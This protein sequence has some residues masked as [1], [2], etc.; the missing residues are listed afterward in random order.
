MRILISIPSLGACT[1]LWLAGTILSIWPVFLIFLGYGIIQIIQTVIIKRTH[2]YRRGDYFLSTVDLLGITLGIFFTGGINSPLFF[3]YFI[4]LIVKVFHRNWELILYNGIGGIVFYAVVILISIQGQWSQQEL[5][6]LG[7]R[8]FFMS[9]P[10]AI[11]ALAVHL[12]RKKEAVNQRRLSRMRLATKISHKLNSVQTLDQIPE[13]AQS[14][15]ANFNLSL[16][17]ELH[18]WS[19]IFLLNDDGKIMR[20]IQDPGNARFDLKQTLAFDSCPVASSRQK[21]FLKDTHQKEECP[22]ETFSFKSHICVPVAGS[23][24]ENFGVIFFGSHQEMPFDHEEVQFL[25]FVGKSLGLTIQRLKKFEEL[26]KTVEMDSCVTAAFVSSSRNVQATYETILEGFKTLLP[27]DQVSIMTWSRRERVLRTKAVS[28]PH[29][30]FELN[31]VFHHGEG[32]PGKVFSTGKFMTTSDLERAPFKS[33]FCLPLINIK[34][35]PIGVVN[36]WMKDRYREI[37]SFDIDRALTFTTR[38][39]SAIENAALHESERNN[40]H[41]R[42][43]IQ[44]A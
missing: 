36:V 3:L 44:A 10:V 12:L 41:T 25:Q 16:G 1:V 26:R 13:A 29:E 22:A 42:D 19:R 21:F 34:G 8:V 32:I 14:L 33:Q 6:G 39:A 5:S 40:G 30:A 4:P 37:D 35:G 24:N 9:I 2:F 7:G 31:A 18:G 28:G 20:A 17:K 23:Q 43:E 27:S 15:V 11:S 38:A